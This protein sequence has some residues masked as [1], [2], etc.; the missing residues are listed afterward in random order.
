MSVVLLWEPPI[1]K[2]VRGRRF[3]DAEDAEA[4]ASIHLDPPGWPVNRR[5]VDLDGFEPPPGLFLYDH[6]DPAEAGKTLD[7][8][9]RAVL[10]DMLVAVGVG[11]DGGGP[12]LH[13]MI[14]RVVP[15]MDSLVPDVHRGIPV[16]IVRTG[17]PR[18]A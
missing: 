18:P 4:W 13:V 2:G 1:N 17:R 16:Q 14:A 5:T 3:S 8:A 15:R 12:V 6:D 11:S 9:M 7:S 10:G